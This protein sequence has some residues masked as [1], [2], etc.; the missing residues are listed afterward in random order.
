MFAKGPQPGTS[1]KKEA[2]KLL[3]SAV[4]R[5]KESG[6]IKGFVVY[7]TKRDAK[8]DRRSISSAG[9]S[10]EAWEKALYKLKW[11]KNNDKS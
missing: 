2:L 11:E 3:H 10:R 7:P 5:R 1:Y 8:A 9:S 4:C 6:S